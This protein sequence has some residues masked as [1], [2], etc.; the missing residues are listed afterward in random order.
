MLLGK[1]MVL[2]KANWQTVRLG[3][4]ILTNIS[5]YSEKNNWE[6]IDYLDTGNITEN[7]I[8]AIQRLYPN[9]DK[10]P[11]RARRKVQKNDIIYSTV[12]SIQKHYGL[13]KEIYP[14]LLVSTGFTTITPS[15]QVDSGF[16]YYYLTQ[17]D[18][19]THL[20]NI[21]EQ[22]VSTYPSIR[23]SDIED[24]QLA[25]PPLP[26]QRSIAATLSCLDD[27]IEL[28]NRINANLEAQAQAIFKSWFV[29]FEPF[30]DGE[31]VDSEL[32]KIPK[33]W[34]VSRLS[35]YINVKDGTHDTPKSTKNGN[36][37]ITSKHLEPYSLK[38]K[39]AY[40]ISKE[41]FDNINKRSKVDKYDILI[42]MIGTVGIINYV[43]YDDISFAIKNM[44]LFKTSKRQ[45][46]AEYLLFYL[47]SL[48]GNRFLL[49]NVAGSTQEFI[50]LT[51]LRNMPFLIPDINTINDFKKIIYPLLDTT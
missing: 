7:K 34:K 13:T 45:D 51:E 29:D 50:S 8:N 4:I 44:G 47:K 24:L 42:S 23:P 30:R 11:S 25:L 28:N 43:L 27:K 46:I 5:S 12:R 48:Y 3:D 35:E 10:L 6:Y 49:S 15:P 16:I 40:Y 32:G 19:I 31:F 1:W 17:D 37:L 9:Q 20:Q 22:S 2:M 21:A 26:I 18:I 41:D 36:K 14:N 38:L 33:G 39:E